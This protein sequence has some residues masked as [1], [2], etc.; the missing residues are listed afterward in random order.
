MGLFAC[1]LLIAAAYGLEY[2]GRMEPCPLCLVQRGFVMAMGAV[3]LFGFLHGAA[4]W[5][6]WV[7]SGVLVLLGVG[8]AVVAGRH[9]WL[10][11]L[12]EE[13]VPACG[14]GLEYMIQT[15]PLLEVLE[16]V[17]MGSGECAEVHAVLGVTI[18]AW[19]LGAF[20]L[21]AIWSLGIARRIR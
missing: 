14:P 2:A 4:G 16:L 17:L 8:G 19:T 10:Q 5:G 3:F 1:L 21:L 18:P 6:R 9:L 13:E 15:F 11:S 12:P 20:V 7:Y